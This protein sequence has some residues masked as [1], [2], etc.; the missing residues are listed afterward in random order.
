MKFKRVKREPTS[1]SRHNETCLLIDDSWDDFGYKT[2][3]S[4]VLFDGRGRRHDLGKVRIMQRDMPPG[5]VNVP[6]EFE[7]L[8]PD[9]CSLG[10]DRD[11]YAAIA[12]IQNPLKRE[13]LEGL[14]DCVK[15][16]NLWAIFQKQ[17]AMETSLLR[18]VSI[19]DVELTF[20]K[21]L[22]G[23]SNLTSYAFKYRVQEG[24]I[25]ADFCDFHV[26]PD[27]RPPTNIHVLVGRNGVGKTRLLAGMADT[28]TA[29]KAA[30]IGLVGRF[31]FEQTYDDRVGF[32]NLVIVSFSAFD[33]FEP[34]RTRRDQTKRAIP[35]YYVGIK[36][37]AG[38]P[39]RAPGAQP[40]VLKTADDFD[41]EFRVALRRISSDS[42]KLSRWVQTMEHLG[43][44]PGI[45]ELEFDKLAE[46]TSRQG[47]IK[48]TEKFKLLSSGHKIVILT[49]TRLVEFVSDR[50]LVLMDEPETHLHP[51]LLGSLIRALSELL[52]TRNGVAIIA[53]HSP[54][55]LQEVPAACVSIIS[56]AGSNI[57]IA[58]PDTET[59]AENVGALTRTVFGLEVDKSGFYKLLSES[60]QDNDYDSVMLAFENQIGGEGRALVRAFVSKEKK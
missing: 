44:D 15:N 49:M 23:H 38:E 14:R 41:S 6:T 24:S 4:A 18:S 36:T 54:V 31:T 10:T 26:E 17:K 32:L 21:V 40:L 5:R 52:A 30:T 46:D 37:K 9:F 1:T 25:G 45:H 43:S 47:L 51:P 7:R 35:S 13:F 28:L 56:R 58:K 39:S 12:K 19:R 55:V 2:S 60:A 3:F 59:F 33:R 50:S 42:S 16:R 48:I 57:R 22:A 27:S 11:Y 8:D 29:N 20:P 53:T 34:I